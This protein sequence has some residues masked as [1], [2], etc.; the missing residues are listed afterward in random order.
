MKK[1]DL[2]EQQLRLISA[3]QG[4]TFGTTAPY[5]FCTPVIERIGYGDIPVVSVSVAMK[6]CINSMILIVRQE[7]FRWLK[8]NGVG[9]GV[10]STEPCVTRLK[11]RKL[12]TDENRSSQSYGQR[13]YGAVYQFTFEIDAA[14]V[15]D[16]DWCHRRGSFKKAEVSDE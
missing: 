14:F 11:A 5:A 8:V 2:A 4:V 1:I 3:S 13:K 12:F 10:V 16:F 6:D 9:A 15:G 7:V